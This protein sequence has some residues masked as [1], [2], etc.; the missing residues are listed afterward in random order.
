M[1]LVNKTHPL[2]DGYKAENL[3]NIYAQNPE[4]FRVLNDDIKINEDVFIA[5]ERMFA[6]ADRNGV[7]GFVVTSGYRSADEQRE[8]YA[9]MDSST[10][11]KPGESEHQT[12][13][14]F[15]VSSSSSFSFESSRGFIWM[16]KHCAEY[17]FIL[18]YPKGSENITGYSYEPWH[19]RYVGLPHSK[20][21]M[22]KGIT[23]EEYIDTQL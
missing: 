7:Y 15:D 13:L 8:L 21:I 14:A 2:P 1:L 22:D 4:Y 3:I 6:A 19:F 12:G 18:R 17:G 16:T 9:T 10:A 20:K 5:M 23:L 11:A